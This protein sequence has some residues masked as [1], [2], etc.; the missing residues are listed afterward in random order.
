MTR[1]AR[2]GESARLDPGHFEPVKSSC[3]CIPTR[4]L[5]PIAAREWQ[6]TRFE[7]AELMDVGKID[8]V[9]PDVGRV[10]G[11]TEAK[12]V[13][14]MAKLLAMSPFSREAFAAAPA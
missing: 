6:T 11:L 2:Q 12:R 13:C 5:P 7:F 8:V 3:W 14:D 10:G 9:Q 1:N 4:A